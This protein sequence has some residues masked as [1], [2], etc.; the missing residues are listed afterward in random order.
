VSTSHRSASISTAESAIIHWMACRLAIGSPKVTRFLACSIAIS[1]S[2]SQAPRARA[3]SMKRP[4]PI[5]FMASAKPRPSSP[6]IAECGTRTSWKDRDAGPHW[7]MVGMDAEVQPASRS[8]R[9]Q[10]TDSPERPSLCLSR[11]V[12]ANTMA[13]SAMSPPVMNVFSPLITHSSPSRTAEVRMLR[14]SE[15]APGSVIA[16]QLYRSPLIVGSR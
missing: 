9:K 13:K 16:K 8:T 14:A 5:H 4:L 2:R 12:T 3:G 6:R 1:T 11:S 7:P 15:P 10:V